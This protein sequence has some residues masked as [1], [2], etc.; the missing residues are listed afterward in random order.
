MQQQAPNLNDVIII[1]GGPAGMSAA[2]VA[3]RARL[4]TVVLNEERPRNRVT[5]ASH[6]FLTR[7][8]AHPLE[9]LAIAKEQLRKY[10]TVRYINARAGAVTATASP[11]DVPSFE[12]ELG[13]G[14]K[15]AARRIVIASGHRDDLAALE[16][17]D[18]GAVY[19]TS[20]FPCPFCDGFEHGD[21]ALALFGGEGVEHFAALLKVWSEDIVVFTNGRP[22]P[23]AARAVLERNGVGL[24]EQPI[25]RLLHTAGVLQAVELEGGEQVARQGGFLFDDA[26]KPANHFAEQLGVAQT[27]SMWGAPALKADEAGKTDVPGVYVI[28]D[29]RIG[30]AGVV[31]AAAEGSHCA[32]QIVHEIAVERWQGAEETPA[33]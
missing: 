18:L 20:V 29:S 1:G 9:L 19:G 31:G 17:P 23:D 27:T 10:E 12:V 7:D 11:S 28:G 26:G 25:Q 2:L 33:P 15:V 5:R 24:R 22:L 6:G 3:G 14:T 30:F 16:I 32:S 21:Q 4:T 8:G 13:D